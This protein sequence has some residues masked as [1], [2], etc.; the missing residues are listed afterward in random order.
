MYF[1]FQDLTALLLTVS[2]AY[3]VLTLP[4][5][6]VRLVITHGKYKSMSSVTKFIETNPIRTLEVP[7]ELLPNLF[8]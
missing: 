2:F 3:V 1:Y 6:L 5:N 7:K 8:K 4:L